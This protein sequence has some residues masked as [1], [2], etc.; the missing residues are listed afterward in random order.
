VGKNILYGEVATMTLDE[1][2]KDGELVRPEVCVSLFGQH[3]SGKSWQPG[4]LR[5]VQSNSTLTSKGS[6]SISQDGVLTYVPNG[7]W[8][9]LDEFTTQVVTTTTRYGD[10]TNRYVSIPTRIVQ[11]PK[12]GIENKKVGG[13]AIGLWGIFGL[14]S[15]I[16]LRHGR[17]KWGAKHD[18]I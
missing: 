1:Q 12:D 3:P 16:A 13:G 18:S 8:Q 10:S 9:G 17:A 6:L 15:M 7:N 14:A 5:T 4:C 11:D 2:L